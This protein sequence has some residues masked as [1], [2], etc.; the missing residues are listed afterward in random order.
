MKKST[1]SERFWLNVD[2]SGG[3][4]SCWPWQKSCDQSM[5]YGFA[6][7][8]KKLQR[9]HRYAWT[10]TNGPIPDGIDVLHECDNPP[11][12]NPKHLFLGTDLENRLDCISKGRAKFARGEATN[13]A[14]ITAKQALEIRTLWES[15]GISQQK[16]GDMF[17]INQRA[18]SKIVLRLSWKHV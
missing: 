9:A 8:G 3:T 13:H 10:L 6:W 15:G 11:C 17:G 5:G 4:D 18:V 2:S 1:P 7:D 14:K 12:C 16:I